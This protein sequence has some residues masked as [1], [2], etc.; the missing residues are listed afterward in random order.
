VKSE[1]TKK[2]LEYQQRGV[3]PTRYKLSSIVFSTQN[4]AVPVHFALNGQNLSLLP[5]A[6]GEHPSG[7]IEGYG[8][9]F[10]CEIVSQPSVHRGGN[11]F[12]IQEAL[13]R[14]LPLLGFDYRLPIEY[15]Q[16]E[17]YEGQ[18]LPL[19]GLAMSA[20][21][22]ISH[23]D[24]PKKTIHSIVAAY[25]KL[26]GRT[27]KRS[28][29]AVAIRGRLKEAIR[30]EN[31]SRRYSFLSYYSIVEIVSDD[32]AVAKDC[33][34]GDT[35]AQEIANFSLSTKGSQR[36]KLYFLLRAIPNDFNITSCVEVADT[37]NDIAHGELTVSAEH[38]D[39]CKKLA[40]WAS[41]AFALKV[42]DEA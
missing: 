14:V 7:M 31:I 5:L 33:P 26:S 25:E 30:L 40:F 6:T 10:R 34:S 13:D 16:W 21:I 8:P 15:Q 9:A 1:D 39:L 38:F 20:S 42:A 12:D 22:L 18:W 3:K 27:D 2:W 24:I 37:R 11:N 41:E 23:L 4:I 17:E 28:K 29:K 36:T 35:I 19:L 32:L